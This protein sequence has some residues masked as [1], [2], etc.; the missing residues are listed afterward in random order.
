MTGEVMLIKQFMLPLILVV[1]GLILGIIAEKVVLRGLRKIAARTKWDI[2]EIF[3]DAFRG[4]ALLWFVLAGIYGAVRSIHVSPEILGPLHKVFI[5]IVILSVTLVLARIS[6]G[7][8]STYSRKVGGVL[9]STTIFANIA[10]AVVFVIGFLVVLQHLGISI[11]PIL[12]ALGVG[13]LAVALALQDT[14]T[15]L[16][17]GIQI[18]ASKQIRPGDYVRLDGGDGGYV[19]DINWRYTTIR[20]LPN[21]MIIIP[22]SKL[23]TAI[24]TNYN[25]PQKEIGITL[26]VSVSYDCDLDDVE[27]ITAEVARQTVQ[28]VEGEIEGFEPVVR[29]HAF[30]DSGINFTVILRAREFV[31]QYG[32][33][34]EFIKRLHRR[35][36]EEGIEIPYP[37]RNVYL[38]RES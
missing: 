35:Y 33:K 14:L 38:N 13:G 6:V 29:Y 24:V 34:H 25:L 19:T 18:I 7:L 27:R 36:K 37:T 17:S 12:T 30:G 8:V 32:L 31:N 20:A 26:D 15:N 2:D 28:E 10:K 1:I 16:F 9:G 23:A 3:A 4:M 21:N 22:N 5:V 11:T